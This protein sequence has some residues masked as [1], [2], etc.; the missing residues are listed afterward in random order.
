MRGLQGKK[1]VIAGGATG[2]GAATAERLVAEGAAVAIGDINLAGAQATAKTLAAAGGTAVAIEFDFADEASVQALID[3]SITELDGIDG[4]FNVGAD[5]S[6]STMAGDVDVLETDIAIWRRTLDVNLIGY[7]LSCKAVIPHLLEQGGGV[8]VNTSSGAAH[9]GEPMRP[10]YA[11]SKAGVSSLTRHISARWGKEGI[12]CNAIAPGI[13]L[14]EGLLRHDISALRAAAEFA[15]R[16]PRLGEPEDLA[17]VAAF[18]LSDDSAYVSGQVWS[19][20][21][22]WTVRE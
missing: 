20:N 12:R 13:V 1:I 6:M 10:A 2:I 7:A 5:L 17:A 8:I 16:G 11:A 19:V 21:G 14:T 3:Q 4:L 9:A 22:G 18:L 15:L